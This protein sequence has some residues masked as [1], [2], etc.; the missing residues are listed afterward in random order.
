MPLWFVFM[1]SLDAIVKTR[2]PVKLQKWLAFFVLELLLLVLF[3]VI[4]HGFGARTISWASCFD[5]VV[6]CSFTS[7]VCVFLYQLKPVNT[8]GSV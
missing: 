5:L 1:L 7:A 2:I 3:A 6:I 4:I 8:R